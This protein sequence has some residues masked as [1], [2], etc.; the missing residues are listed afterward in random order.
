[1][2]PSTRST[3]RSAG[4]IGARRPDTFRRSTRPPCRRSMRCLTGRSPASQRPHPARLRRRWSPCIRPWASVARWWACGMM[5]R[6]AAAW[7][8]PAPIPATQTHCSRARLPTSTCAR[9]RR[10]NRC[11]R[12]H[13]TARQHSPPSLRLRWPLRAILCELHPPAL[14]WRCCCADAVVEPQH[15]R[16]LQHP[17]SS[18]LGFGSE[19][20]H[21]FM[22]A[23]FKHGCCS[24]TFWTS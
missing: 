15:G 18:R 22:T 13:G 2:E 6:Q 11:H 16:T 5:L 9:W 17:L 23:P 7:P 21:A 4:H 12:R 14:C 3:S 8:R 20:M 10:R 24:Q 1:M 19:A